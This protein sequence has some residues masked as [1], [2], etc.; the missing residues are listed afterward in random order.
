LI[1]ARV[2]PAKVAVTA[3]GEPI[4][5]EEFDTE[6]RLMAIHYSAVSGSEMRSIKRR[7]FEQVINRR[8]LAQEAKKEGIRISSREWADAVAEALRE[9]PEDFPGVL[10]AQGVSEEAWKRKLFQEKL[11]RKIVE[12]AVNAKVSISSREVEEYYWSH[13]GDFWSPRAVHGAH[14]VVQ[15]AADLRKALDSLARGESFSAVASRLSLG[16]E[17]TQ[18]G[19]WGFVALDRLPAAYVKVLSS[20]KPGETSPPLRDALGFHLFQL[21]GWKPRQMRDFSEVRRKIYD[22]LL[23]DEQDSRFEEWMIR[24]KRKAVI[25]VNPVLAPVAGIILEGSKQP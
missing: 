14:L 21:V 18:G 23:K 8:L 4:S 15:E 12:K 5:L 10:K 13:L 25:R 22:G 20:L 17:R 19:D 9:I 2:P 7:L 3:N 1:P 24:L 11:A 6:F 16:P